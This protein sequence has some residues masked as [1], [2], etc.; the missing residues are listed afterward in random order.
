MRAI[1]FSTAA[2]AAL[3]ASA[4]AAA[5]PL[6]S[7]SREVGMGSAVSADVS[8]FAANYFNPAGLAR[9]RSAEITLGY[10]MADYTE[11]KS[12]ETSHLQLSGFTGGVVA[13]GKLL[14]VPLV[15]GLA[16]QRLY[17]ATNLAIRPWE[18]LQIGGGLAFVSGTRGHLDVTGGANIYR[19]EQSQL[20]HAVDASLTA[21]RYPQLGVRV[22]LSKRAALALVY[23]GGY[24][25]GVDLAARLYADISGLTTARYDYDSRGQT[26]FLPQQVVFG[27]AWMASDAVRVAGDVTWVNYAAID[28]PAPVNMTLDVPPPAG[29]WPPS[30]PP[31]RIPPAK[32]IIPVKEH[33]AVIPRVGVEWRAV[34]TPRWEGFVRGG[35]EFFK[36]TTSYQPGTTVPLDPHRHALS[37][38]LGARLVPGGS[39]L[40][41]SI[42][43]DMHLRLSIPQSDPAN[44]Y[45]SP[46]ATTVGLVLN[47]GA[48]L[49]V[50]F[51]RPGPA[52]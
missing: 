19:P 45:A 46:D 2:L 11:T 48:M 33:D 50:A 10:S 22:E 26:D 52:R 32:V 23:R 51:D 4:T 34:Q 7:G 31:P 12:G 14:G 20:R 24:K 49:T 15:F 41:G 17:I 1:A 30:V 42:R 13:P 36:S 21:V 9:T 44:P 43:L 37:A 8:G 39:A 47:A 40:P 27:G 35:Y 3:L 18:W 16:I 25:Q 5:A 6:G 38:G 29:G 28:P